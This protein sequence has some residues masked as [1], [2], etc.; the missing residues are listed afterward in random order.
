MWSKPRRRMV[1]AG[2]T[3]LAASG[4]LLAGVLG[5]SATGSTT[6]VSSAAAST[7]IVTSELLGVSAVSSGNAWAVGYTWNGTARTTI[8]DHWNGRSW[9]R[10][11]APNP[12][13]HGSLLAAVTATSATNAWA[14]GNQGLNPV[15]ARALVEHWN[16]TRW[17]VQSSPSPSAGP[18]D[19]FGVAAVSA[20]SAWAVGTYAGSGKT[21]I[22]HWNGSTWSIQSSP[23]P[24]N[25]ANELLSVTALSATNVW[26]SGYWT[27]QG[28]AMHAL[29][30]H[31]DGSRWSVQPS[32]SQGTAW[33]VLN[34]VAIAG[35]VPWSAGT[36]DGPP[37]GTGE[38]R[39]MLER[40][41]STGWQ[42]LAMPALNATQYGLEAI[43]AR[44]ANSA[45]ATGHADISGKAG[46]QT[47][48]EH[49]NGSRWSVQP[50]PSP[51]L[52]P[53]SDPQIWGHDDRLE[54]V[55]VLSGTSVWAAGFSGD[56]HTGAAKTL[57]EHWNGKVWQVQATPSP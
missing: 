55:A 27:A 47:L 24:G 16:G 11:A 33:N 29:I 3:A 39:G 18:V 30:E 40:R 52:Q 14:V 45:W 20:R 10:Q 13:Y 12:G 2:A 37:S 44:Y 35:A 21:L 26:A 31:W 22:E 42:S 8:I 19:L 7:T 25:F 6:I 50:S 43:G 49:W 53:L 36:S 17:S 32:V 51:S 4:G 5:T 46:T 34:G 1:L 9:S 54:A 48:I 15:G 23:N 38:Q 41:T 28:G 56:W 57:I